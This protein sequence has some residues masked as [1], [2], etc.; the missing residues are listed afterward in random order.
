MHEPTTRLEFEEEQEIQRAVSIT[1]AMVS[2]TVQDAVDA[3]SASHRK[4]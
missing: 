4:K 3:V 2:P 1:N